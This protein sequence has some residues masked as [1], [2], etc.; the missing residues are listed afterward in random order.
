M[1]DPVR[2]LLALFDALP[3]PEKQSAAAEILRRAPAAG[4]VPVSALDGLAD[5]LFAALDAEE[6]AR[7]AGR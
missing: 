5:E 4:D 7:A 2:Q 1:S 3:D 6:S